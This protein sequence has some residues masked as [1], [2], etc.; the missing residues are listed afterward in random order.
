MA[1]SP[2]AE[3]GE[4]V[5]RDLGL[6]LAKEARQAGEIART[7]A[8]IEQ[9]RA[10]LQA[11]EAY[12]GAEP[13]AE[14]GEPAVPQPAA[15]VLLTADQRPD[16]EDAKREAAYRAGILGVM[17]AVPGRNAWRPNQVAERLA[18]PDVAGIRLLM[19]RMVDERV[20][21]KSENRRYRFPQEPDDA[22]GETTAM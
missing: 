1:S 15:L 7:R 2:Q 17:R 13:T 19:D 20:L 16:P 12:Y 14:G 18:A 11:L 6:L 9:A 22:L 4:S 5:L 8:E 10:L 3:L 21:V